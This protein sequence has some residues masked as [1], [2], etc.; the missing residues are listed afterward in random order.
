[1]NGIY[2]SL[3]IIGRHWRLAFAAAAIFGAGFM[4]S[5][6]AVRRQVTPLIRFSLWI[7]NFFIRRLGPDPALSR[8]A[9]FIFCFNSIAIFLYMASGVVPYLPL[10]IDLVTGLNV[11]IIV[12]MAGS[13]EAEPALLPGPAEE[14]FDE[15]GPLPSSS[16]MALGCGMLVLMLELPAFWFAI[17]LGISIAQP[18]AAGLPAEQ[19]LLAAVQLRAFIYLRAVMPILALSAIAEAIAIRSTSAPPARAE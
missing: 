12:Q 9:A 10:T 6:V 7:L 1:M 16:L 14:Q 3:C 19:G 17:A 4:L 15:E 18:N 13:P 2:D 11:G 8:A 5:F